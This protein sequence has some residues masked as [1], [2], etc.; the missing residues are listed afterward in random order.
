MQ[1]IFLYYSGH[2][3]ITLDLSFLDAEL[4]RQ[5][6]MFVTIVYRKPA[7]TF[8]G[9]YTQFHSFLPTAYKFV[10]AYTLAFRCFPICS[11]WTNFHNDL[12]FLK[13]IFL[14]NG[15]PISFIDKCFETFL[16]Q[17]YLKRLQVLTAE[18]SLERFP[19]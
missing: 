1:M 4:S 16:D 6:N 13:D 12:T 15:Y 3:I 9:V 18:K 7:F 2:V 19:F 14:N 10:M 11:K 5:G 17:I 8:S